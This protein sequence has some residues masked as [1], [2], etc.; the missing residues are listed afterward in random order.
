MKT[1]LL[2]SAILGVVALGTTGPSVGA[3][4]SSA[5]GLLITIT[6]A[7]NS[8][9][10]VS[11]LASD[12]ELTTETLTEK[13]SFEYSQNAEIAVLVKSETKEQRATLSMEA[14]GPRGGHS[15]A[16]ISAHRISFTMTGGEI[17]AMPLDG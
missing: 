3:S 11:I 5:D 6:P 17:R 13:K 9:C 4:A 8:S 14:N 10:V 7:P 12:S 1:V 15:A 2:I 16:T